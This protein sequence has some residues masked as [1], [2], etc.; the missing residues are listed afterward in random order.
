MCK[1]SLNLDSY[2][3]FIHFKLAL[4]Q[5]AN[6]FYDSVNAK[7]LLQ[8]YVEKSVDTN[9]IPHLKFWRLQVIL[10]RVF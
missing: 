7:F 6:I 8:Y 10:K 5:Q 3:L 2:V 9:K 4:A 1:M